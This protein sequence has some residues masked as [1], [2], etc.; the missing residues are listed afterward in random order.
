MGLNYVS[1][2]TS[3]QATIAESAVPAIIRTNRF[4]GF[5]GNEIKLTFFTTPFGFANFY[6][7]GVRVWQIRRTLNNSGRFGRASVRDLMSAP[8]FIKVQTNCFV[9][10]DLG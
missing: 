5:Y 10:H 8:D 1:G 9:N 3:F 4:H 2:S 7:R 6:G